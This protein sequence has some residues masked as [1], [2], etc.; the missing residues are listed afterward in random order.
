[1]GKAARDHVRAYFGDTHLLRWAELFGS[2]VGAAGEK[3]QATE[4]TR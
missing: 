3:R 1:M 2:L 4:R